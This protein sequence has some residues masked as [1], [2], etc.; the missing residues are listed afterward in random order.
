M[1]SGQFRTASADA[2]IV[3]KLYMFSI[4]EFAL[5]CHFIGL[6]RV[7][8]I[9]C[10]ADA[11]PMRGRRATAWSARTPRLFQPLHWLNNHAVIIS[12]KQHSGFLVALAMLLLVAAALLGSA[13]GLAA[14]EPL[15]AATLA[16]LPPADAGRR[17]MAAVE[18]RDSG[19]G[20]LSVDLRM[21]LRTRDGRETQRT[22][23]IQQLEMPADGDRMMVVFETPKAIRGTALLSYAHAEREDDQ[24]LFLPAFNR[25]R[26]IASRNRSGPFVSSEFAFEDL[27]PAELEKYRYRYLGT[28]PCG[29][30]TCLA[31][32]R[33]PLETYSGYSRHV[34]RVH[35]RELRIE[36]IDYYNRGGALLKTLRQTGFARYRDRYWRPAEMLMTNQLTGKSTLLEWSNYEFGTGLS[37]E[38]D[39]SVASLRR[40]R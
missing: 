29:E 37:A 5:A 22:L 36:E 15:D 10:S 13:R 24:W 7:R 17:L 11:L 3:L 16:A 23:R 8:N 19:F 32:E 26:K 35:P 34:V 31:V 12:S 27:T 2:G 20:D 25:V 4:S 1:I 33:T 40:Q 18:A 28:E 30:Q 39:F 21:R 38:R 9:S 6:P 14:P